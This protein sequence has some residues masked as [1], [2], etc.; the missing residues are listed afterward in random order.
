MLLL[1]TVCT[2][3]SYVAF[4][5][6]FVAGVLFLLQERQL[7]RKTLGRLF[8]RLPPLEVLDGINFIALGAGCVLLTLGVAFGMARWRVSLGQWGMGDPKVSITMLLW[9]GYVV[10]WV[11]RLRATLRGRRVAW[12]SAL[13]F[14]LVVFTALGIGWIVPTLHPSLGH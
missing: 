1:H 4:L 12:L 3:L 11:V 2:W 9:V 14:S 13:G 5:V 7:K 6:A 10:L 8:Y